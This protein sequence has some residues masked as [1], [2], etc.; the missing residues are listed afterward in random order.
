M[1]A[2]FTVFTNGAIKEKGAPRLD[3]EV[4]QIQQTDDTLVVQ[5]LIQKDIYNL[6]DAKFN[7]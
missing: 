2:F 5:K 6:G 7:A 3:L 1:A 4:A